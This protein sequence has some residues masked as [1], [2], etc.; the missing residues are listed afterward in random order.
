[1]QFKKKILGCRMWDR[2]PMN[3]VLFP[4]LLPSVMMDSPI[5]PE[6]LKKAYGNTSK[7]G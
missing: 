6:T 5:V 3:G 7:K 1:M 2:L 4:E